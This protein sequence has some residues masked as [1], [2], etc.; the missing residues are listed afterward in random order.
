MR[1]SFGRAF[2]LM[3]FSSAFFILQFQ[4]GSAQCL[5]SRWASSPATLNA[6]SFADS[7]H[8]MAVGNTGIVLVTSDGG[9]TWDSRIPD[10][11]TLRS[12]SI[13]DVVML[14]PGTACVIARDVFVTTDFGLT[15][16][17]QLRPDNP[18]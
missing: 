5:N 18:A 3:S 2:H 15:W 8:G 9:M 1:M 11:S 6:I 7:L 10:D 16:R 14:S 4:T 12:R 17:L 13:D